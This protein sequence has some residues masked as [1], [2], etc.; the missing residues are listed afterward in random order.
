MPKQKSSSQIHVGD[1]AGGM[2]PV[3]DLRFEVDEWPIELV[4]PANDAET[5]MAHL[6]AEMQERGWNSSGL[7]QMETAENSGTF[8]V[9]AAN[10]P[11][12]PTL[13]IVW[14][15]PRDADLRV[16]ARS[17][18]S[19]IMSVDL[20]RGFIDAVNE[21]ARK[22]ITARAHRWD[23]L[24]YHGLPW[25][26]ELWLGDDVRLGPPSRFPD[27]LLGPQVVVIDAM[28]DGIGHSGITANFQT[29]MQDLRIFLGVVLGICATPVRPELGWVAQFDEQRRPTACTLQSIGYW[30][31]GPPRTFPVRGS[32]PPVPRESVVRP[33]VGRTG[34]WPDMCERWVPADIEDLRRAF[35]ALPAA[36]RDNLLRAGNA[37]L[38]AHSMWPDQ[39]TAYAVFL[40]VA[41]EALK[42]TGKQYDQMN[43][44]G[45]FASLVGPG[46]AVRLR[47]LSIHPQQVRN[48]HVHRGELAAGEL[49]PML[50]HNN[51]AD[52]SLDEML[53][54]LSWICRVCLIEWLRCGGQYKVVHPPRARRSPATSNTPLAGRKSP[55]K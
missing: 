22:R 20:A 12:P 43:V 3:A 16:R 33:G 37:Y 19:P 49:L 50:I 27:A 15:K 55:G 4:I 31:V 51:F 11:S 34:I 36:K 17:G 32:C 38:I 21:R 5:W 14:E 53:S 8:S 42:P 6:S 44:Y 23:L 52:P 30:E 24:T 46:E 9:H 41:C 48:R 26:G 18:G 45:V 54:E 1:G 40:V 39:R 13:H 7:S 25:R 2:R 47:E 35:T 10:G 29:R 28:V